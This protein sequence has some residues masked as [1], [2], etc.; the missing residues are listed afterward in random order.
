MP[1][2]EK[3]RKWWGRTDDLIEDEDPKAH[4]K[5][6]AVIKAL[7]Q[8]QDHK[9]SMLLYGAMYSGGVPPIGGG[10]GVDSYVRTSPNNMGNLSLNISR[11][12]AD[13]VVSRLFSKGEPTLTYVTEG[14]DYERQA[15]AKKL[16]QG[17]EGSFYLEGASAVN[18]GTG[19][20]GVVFGTG[21]TRVEPNFDE[22]KVDIEK[23]MPWECILD[24][25]E[26]LIGEP[27]NWYTARYYD[28]YQLAYRYRD[29]ANK[30]TLIERLDSLWD[31]DA[32]FGYSAVAV[33]IRVEEAWHR[34]S[35]R[36]ANDG[37]HVIG[38]KNCTLVDEPWDGGPPRRPWR[39]ATYR[40]SK[41]LIGFYGQGLVELGAGIQAEIN[42]LMRDIQ[43]GLKM[44]KGHWLVEENSQ[45]RTAHLNNDLT[46]IIRFAG[47]AP[48]YQAPGSVIPREEYEHLWNLVSKYYEL[49]GINQQTAS[50][51]K[52]P[53]LK[54]GE[55]QRV[56]ADQQTEVLLEK[57]KD[58]EE[59]VREVGQLVT[60]SARSL[61]KKGAYE[62]RS[63]DDDGFESI[64]WKKLDD[65]DGYELRVHPTSTLPGTPS[66]RIDL[67]YD[68]L[69][70]GQFD[71][72]D[73]MELVGMP[74]ILQKTR[75]KQASR[76]LVEKK[77]GEMLRGGDSYE[78]SAFLNCSEA[79]VIATE[80]L[81][82]A[83]E[84]GVDDDRLEKVRAFIQACDAITATKPAPAAPTVATGAP[85]LA[86]GQVGAA[87]AAPP[88]GPMP[89]PGQ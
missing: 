4:E 80:M 49:A 40:W 29:D 41:P 6:H 8:N 48:V 51:Q 42:K 76:R 20:N 1:L 31:E 53:E 74:D 16:E 15:N 25:T 71:S 54:S 35:G 82:A 37:R 14:G 3:D 39:F 23:W 55:A 66:G 84:K 65:P 24:D 30:A 10:M 22:G 79:S 21:F 58:F 70:L 81:N 56:Y 50:A 33:R 32:Q 38:I 83:E 46:T 73:V 9:L 61:S 86:P 63:F 88:A 7:E 5:L 28:K 34:P 75:L 64:D 89:P 87:P 17:V 72:A 12:C 13:A 36:E 45:V 27:R 67:A 11:T 85:M 62:V 78:P 60:D 57:G 59:Y 77:V 18:V 26:T 52:P 68:M 43:L 19:R 2:S 69:A 47:T 44:V